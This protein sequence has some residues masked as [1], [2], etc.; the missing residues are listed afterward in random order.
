MLFSGESLFHPNAEFYYS[1]HDGLDND[2]SIKENDSTLN[3]SVNASMYPEIRDCYEISKPRIDVTSNSD[4]LARPQKP[5]NRRARKKKT[6]RISPLTI[7]RRMFQYFQRFAIQNG[8][9]TL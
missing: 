3:I 2:N 7:A 4:L 1:F 8:G 6:E 5:R 9:K